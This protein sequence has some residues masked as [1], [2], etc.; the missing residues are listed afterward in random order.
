MGKDIS[1]AALSSPQGAGQPSTKD[2]IWCRHYECYK[3]IKVCNNCRI[4]IKCMSYKDHWQIRLD[5]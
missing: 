4:R 1:S 3:F 2:M 5:F